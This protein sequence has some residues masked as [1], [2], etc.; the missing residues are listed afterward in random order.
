MGTARRD[1]AR[2]GQAQ[3]PLDHQS[4]RSVFEQAGFRVDLLEYFDEGGRFCSREWE[5]RDGMIHRSSEFD[6][7]NRDAPLSY[8]SII[9]DARK[10]PGGSR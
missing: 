4:F 5:P 6:E 3:G 9:L 7:R 10:G 2:R 1:G 8:I